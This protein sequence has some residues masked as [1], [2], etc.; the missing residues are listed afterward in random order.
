MM[1]STLSMKKSEVRYRESDSAYSFHSC[2]K[3][4]CEDAIVSWFRTK[5]PAERGLVY[6]TFLP[7]P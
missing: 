5:Y 1:L 3:R 7:L 4:D 2:A 6:L